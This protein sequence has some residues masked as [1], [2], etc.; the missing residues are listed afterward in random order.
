MTGHA[1]T[2][3]DT[4]PLEGM[5]V[6]VVYDC[7]FP[8][9]V[10]GAERWYRALAERL[11]RAG[12]AVTY[13]TRLQWEG[14]PPEIPGV[15]VVAVMG[16]DELY[17]ADGTRRMGPPLR[18]GQAVFSWL[19]R[20]RSEVDAVHVANFPY[21]SLLAA[22]AALAGS[23]VPIYADWLEVWPSSFWRSYVGAAAGTVGAA[24]QRLCIA[25]T[26]HALVFWEANAERLR[27]AGHRGTV[28]VLAG[29]LPAVPAESSVNLASPSPPVVLFAGRHI[30]D[31]GVRLLPETLELARLAVPALELVVA[32]DGPESALVSAEVERRHLGEA[33]RL[34]GRVLDDEL[35]RLLAGATCTVVPSSREGYGMIVVESAAVGTPVVVAANPEN[36]AVGH[37]VPGVN[38]FVVDPTPAGLAN[39]IVQAVASGDALRSTTASWYEKHAGSMAMERATAEVVELYAA[40]RSRSRRRG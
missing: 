25:L 10:G 34:T 11:A 17:H 29:L 19:V 32:G 35:L 4:R 26:P 38:G 14:G 7:L 28:T 27:R 13:L 16:G 30:K 15:E 22:R 9:T 39:G 40:D 36:L 33:V 8:L 31:K 5:R 12:A 23:G 6:C 3:P 2:E 20:H 37:I 1:G 18:F 21:F 24:V